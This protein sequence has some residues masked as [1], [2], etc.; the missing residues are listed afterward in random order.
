MKSATAKHCIKTQD[1]MRPEAERFLGLFFKA[2]SAHLDFSALP[3]PQP[4]PV[5][6]NSCIPDTWRLARI[7]LS[8]LRKLIDEEYSKLFK[9]VA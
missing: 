5:V 2:T 7:K 1:R 4:W 8:H 3:Q 9:Y 6:S